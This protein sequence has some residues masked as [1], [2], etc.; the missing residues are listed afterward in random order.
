MPC[1]HDTRAPSR[2]S[3]SAFA[4]RCLA[5]LAAALATLFC[6]LRANGVSWCDGSH[7]QVPA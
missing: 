3:R 2:L 6:P 1:R 7:E 5:M 4:F